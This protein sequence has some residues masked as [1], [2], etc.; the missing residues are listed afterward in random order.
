MKFLS[1]TYSIQWIA[2]LTFVFVEVLQDT[3]DKDE[4]MACTVIIIDSW[5]PCSA[6]ICPCQ[7][8]PTS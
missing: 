2:I 7:K 6:H 3:E 8:Y 4:C 1:C 5:I